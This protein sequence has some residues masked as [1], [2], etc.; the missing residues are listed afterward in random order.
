M[1]SVNDSTRNVLKKTFETAADLYDEAR[2]SYPDQL[3][4]DLIDLVDLEP[5]AALLEIG[6]GTGKATVPLAE[7]GYRIVALE[8]G[9]RLATIARRKLVAFPNV[10]VVTDPFE[11]WD[12]AGKLFVLVYAASAWHWIDPKIRF[13]KAAALL[14]PG[15]ALAFF[16]SGHAF[17]RDADPFFFEIQSVYEEIGETTP[18]DQW[19]PP[20]PEA[21]DDDADEIE[22]SGLFDDVRVR[23][24]VWAQEYDADGYIALLNTFSGHIAMAAAKRDFLYDEIRKRIASR[25]S[26]TVRRHWIAILH[27]ARRL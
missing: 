23:R 27:V 3:F 20:P 16:R 13:E 24:Y 22:A 6:A 26:H 11:S 1:A 8:A 4:D 25:P 15:G 12:P 5:G 19:P 9:N 10:E 7:R 17:P 2:P 21:V 14:H 18:D